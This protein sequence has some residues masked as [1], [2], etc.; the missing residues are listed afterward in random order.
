M[1]KLILFVV[2]LGL[3]LKYGDPFF[4]WISVPFEPT[5]GFV[6]LVFYIL[7]H[8]WN[9][10]SQVRK[11]GDECRSLR[12][13]LLSTRYDLSTLRRAFTERNKR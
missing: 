7:F 11:L 5:H 6:L 2:G 12:S 4:E 1:I 13:E 10:R 8:T 9:T 3:L